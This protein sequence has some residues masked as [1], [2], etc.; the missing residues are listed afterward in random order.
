MIAT[1]GEKGSA[2]V[3]ILLVV[4]LTSILGVALLTVTL[5]GH[6]SVKASENQTKS[7][8]LAEV[9]AKAGYWDL[10]QRL[11]HLHSSDW[12]DV[13]K[14]I[15]S[16]SKDFR[17]SPAAPDPTK[18]DETYQYQLVLELPPK[19]EKP[20]QGLYIVSGYIEGTG[21]SQGKTSTVRIK[22]QISSLADVFRFAMS[23][24]DTIWLNGG[25]K[26]NGDIYAKNKLALHEFAHFGLY[27]ESIFPEVN[28]KISS[29]DV[30]SPI[31]SLYYIPEETIS[32]PV[33]DVQLVNEYSIEGKHNVDQEG[34]LIDSDRAKDYL[35]GSFQ[36]TKIQEVTLPEIDFAKK[37]EEIRTKA[38]TDSRYH[39]VTLADLLGNEH[40]TTYLIGSNTLQGTGPYNGIWYIYGDLVIDGNVEI[41]G[42]FYVEGDVTI[43]NI[44]TNNPIPAAIVAKGSIHVYNNNQFQSS[45][46]VLN[47]FLW[48]QQDDLALYGVISNLQIN[49]GVIAKNIVLNGVRG[50]TSTGLGL[51]VF[52]EQTLDK[53]ARLTITHDEKFVTNPPDGVPTITGLKVSQIGNWV[54]SY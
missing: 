26:I 25:V 17:G 46:A 54:L 8:Y 23:A 5:N 35:N 22:V 28:G 43:R 16:L 19:V 7:R 34:I 52:D 41:N 44:H 32:V 15:S 53:P 2:L 20:D 1:K 11:A 45:P 33:L 9:G 27:K 3:T 40:F 37:R 50:N 51:L 39:Y 6:K 48:T 31:H 42:T 18:P 30:S 12:T 14:E 13:T 38:K 10:Q 24:S 49:G 4:L 36:L 47:A 21:T 29:G